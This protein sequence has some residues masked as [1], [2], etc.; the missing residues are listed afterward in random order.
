MK[1]CVTNDIIDFYWETLNGVAL[2]Q[3]YIYE[4]L[5]HTWC[6]VHCGDV[7]IPFKHVF[8]CNIQYIQKE[9]SQLLNYATCEVWLKR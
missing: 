7:H 1:W 3:N 4:V 5:S 9:E 8:E 2:F 6:F